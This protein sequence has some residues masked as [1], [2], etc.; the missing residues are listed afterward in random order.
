MQRAARDT[1]PTLELEA[2]REEATHYWLEVQDRGEGR[3]VPLGT[4]RVVVGSRPSGARALA[5]VDPTVSAEHCALVVGPRGVV[6]RDLGSR[7]GTFVGGARVAEALCAPGAVMTVGTTTLSVRAGSADEEEETEALRSVRPLEGIAGSSLAM[8]KVARDVRR[9]AAH[10]EPVLVSG[11]T[12]TGKELVARA[13]HVE[14]PRVARPFVALN[15]AALP[16]ELVESE[17]FGHERGA[18]TGAVTRRAGAFVEADGGTLFL[19]EIGELPLDAQPKLLRA[20]DGYEV[21]AVG[22][23]GSGRAL[24]VRLVAATHV[25]MAER[26]A[27]GLFRRDLFHRL[28]VFVIEIPP[29]RERTG[30]VAAIAVRIL[31]RLD[32]SRRLT[33]TSSA[34][35]RLVAYDW[36][37][38][39]R[40]LRNVLVRAAHF[41]DGHTAISAQD[42]DKSLRVRVAARVALSPGL[43]KALLREHGGNLSAAARAAGMARTTFRKL[44]G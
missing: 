38:N 19:D 8:R 31:N 35:A 9:L 40:E 28:E 34:L 29:L 24:Q 23:A 33:L 3:V 2:E 4:D 15:V 20:L 11:E 18:F 27:A 26:V 14:G 5:V 17:L 12:G 44:L 32:P 10:A 13:L 36:P 6:V 25:A 43:A 21:R 42:V 22:A 16:R 39:V 37:G 7:N 41:A 30:D 1:R